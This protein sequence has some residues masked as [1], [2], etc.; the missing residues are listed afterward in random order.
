MRWKSFGHSRN[1]APDVIKRFNFLTTIGANFKD[2]DA[3]VL[4]LL[5]YHLIKSNV[6]IYI[7][8]YRIHKVLQKTNS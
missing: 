5:K 1:V 8:I 2:S 3:S 4:W 7:Y 6:Y